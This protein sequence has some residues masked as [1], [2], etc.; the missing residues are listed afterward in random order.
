MTAQLLEG[1]SLAAT[2]RAELSRE[3]AA[4]RAAGLQVN[5][6]A[7]VV[8]DRPESLAYARSQ[9]KAC[10]ELGM[11]FRLEQLPAAISQQALLKTIQSLNADSA[12]HGI[13]LQLPLPARLDAR[14]SQRALDP[15]KDAE[16][17]HP[18]NLG[19]IVH[20]VS[21]RAPCTAL[22]AYHLLKSVVPNLYGKEAVVVGASTIVGRPLG[23]LLLHDFCTVTTCHIATKDLSA[24]TRR[25]EILCV[26]CGVPE[27]VGKEMVRPG[28]IVVDIG[29]NR[30]P[31]HGPDGLPALDARGRP[32]ERTVGDVDFEGVRQV[33]GWITPVLGGVGPLTVAMLLRNVVESAKE[34]LEHSRAPDAAPPLPFG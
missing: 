26:A 2:Q 3:I 32:K 13:L 12:I 20:G 17:V 10:E 24:F 30:V 7:I 21:R 22:A 28:A 16:G 8:G 4:L 9:K 15:A 11:A 5:L 19:M 34:A 29:Y 33:A 23:L 31:V 1:G 27:R 14:L 18:A 6:A 25:A